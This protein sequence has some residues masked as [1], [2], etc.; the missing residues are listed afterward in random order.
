MTRYPATW[1]AVGLLLAIAAWLIAADVTYRRAVT[2]GIDRL[3]SLAN[4]PET[5]R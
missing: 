5:S 2:G 4:S 1:L 3:E